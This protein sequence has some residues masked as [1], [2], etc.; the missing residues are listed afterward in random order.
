MN[1]TFDDLVKDAIITGEYSF[2][3]IQWKRLSRDC[4]ALPLLIDN[5]SMVDWRLVSACEWALPL[6]L[7]YPGRV[8]WAR[9]PIADWS[10][11]LIAE[12]LEHINWGELS[13]YR[14]VLL[15]SINHSDRIVW[16]NI[17]SEEWALPLLLDR[18]NITKW[19]I[20]SRYEWAVPLLS[21]YPNRVVWDNLPAT[22]WASSLHRYR[23]PICRMPKSIHRSKSIPRP[24]PSVYDQD[25]DDIANI[26]VRALIPRTVIGLVQQAKTTGR[27]EFT[28]DQWT[29][30]SGHRDAL[31]LLHKYPNKVQWAITSQKEW[32]LPLLMRY[33]SHIDWSAL[34]S[35]TAILQAIRND[36]SNL[37]F[38][39]LVK[40]K[41][42]DSFSIG[43]PMMKLSRSWLLAEI[44]EYVYHPRFIQRW[45]DGGRE[46]E[47]YLN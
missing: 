10:K 39:F 23:P 25:C 8:M 19:A 41:L 30:F 2:T 34:S 7:Q 38:Q 4:N 35:S 29:R 46:V 31:Y 3:C 45:L 47:D 13:R 11:L 26:P 37:S 20:V 24:Y 44:A 18:P 6:L 16:G 21:K 12:C 43:Y 15:A 22:T 5:P 42:G 28:F 32:A 17:P 1:C 33:P 36:P 40:D 9:V 27:Y 14:I